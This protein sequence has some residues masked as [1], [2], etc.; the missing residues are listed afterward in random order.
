[1]RKVVIE[2]P[3]AGDVERNVKYACEAMKDCLQRGEAPIASHL[4]YTR[5]LDDLV[6]AQRKLGITS[7][8]VWGST[9]DCIVFYTDHGWSDGMLKAHEHWLGLGIPIENRRLYDNN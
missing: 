3:Y 7:G 8:L 5:V 2:S 6:P 4:L 1:M 9:A